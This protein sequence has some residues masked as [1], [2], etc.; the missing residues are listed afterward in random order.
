M[1]KG[2]C[3][4]LETQLYLCKELGFLEDKQY[5]S[6]MVVTQNILKMLS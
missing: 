5:E 1:A 2:S 4:E 3:A 6:L